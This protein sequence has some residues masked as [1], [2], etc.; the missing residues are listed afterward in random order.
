MCSR[1][2]K[3]VGFL[4]IVLI[5]QGCTQT[6]GSVSRFGQV[7]MI[8]P[9]NVAKYQKLHAAAWPEVVAGLKAHKIGNYSIFL[10]ELEEGKPF[11]FG[12]FEYGGQDFDGDMAKM[13]ENPTVQKWEDTA[14]GECLVDQSA[15]GKGIWWVDMEEVFY[16]AGQTGK[17]VDES[18]RELVMSIKGESYD[19]R[20]SYIEEMIKKPLEDLKLFD[21]QVPAFRN[22]ELVQGSVHHV[23]SLKKKS[24]SDDLDVDQNIRPIAFEI[25]GVV[26]ATN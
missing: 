10:K 20:I 21:Q 26:N 7:A 8:N 2:G 14:G 6:N 25:R 12:Y 17:K 4:F 18:K 13:M 23:D 19:P 9:E 15:D 1:I 5:A 24:E 11:L 16:H 22:V 3:V